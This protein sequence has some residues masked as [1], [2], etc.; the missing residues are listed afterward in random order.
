M[1]DIDARQAE[2]ARRRA[3]A[4]GG[5]YN[6]VAESADTEDAVLSKLRL[7]ARHALGPQVQQQMEIR[8]T[9]ERITGQM[10]I[11]LRALVYGLNG[12][13]ASKQ[14]VHTEPATWWDH[15]KRDWRERATTL[16]RRGVV[17]QLR[18]LITWWVGRH[19]IRTVAKV[20][21]LDFTEQMMFPDNEHVYPESLGN[22]VVVQVINVAQ[23]PPL[24]GGVKPSD[25]PDPITGDDGM[26][27][28]ELVARL[29][30]LGEAIERRAEQRAQ[31]TADGLT[32]EQRHVGV[33]ALGDDARFLHS[34]AEAIE[35]SSKRAL[36]LNLSQLA[37]LV[38]DR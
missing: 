26:E 18:G 20:T 19:P 21:T 5:P 17:G 14:I 1:S 32:P 2:E 8:T 11:E 15:L 10:L 28:L 6:P 38:S 9:M 16:P 23:T 27:P 7:S 31:Y 34:L 22:A 37:S 30:E 24:D 13:E 29:H 33:L 25:L 35:Q 12:R 4:A 3:A 36:P